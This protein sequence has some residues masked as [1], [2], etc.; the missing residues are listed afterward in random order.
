MLSAVGG[1][2]AGAW[3]RRADDDDDDD[4]DEVGA[5]GGAADNSSSLPTMRFRDPTSSKIDPSVTAAAG[6]DDDD[7]D[8]EVAVRVVSWDPNAATSSCKD[9]L[10]AEML[11]CEREKIDVDEINLTRPTQAHRTQ[12]EIESKTNGA[13]FSIVEPH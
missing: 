7:D 8:D 3:W 6:A 5:G 13:R 9:M 10:N 12:D 2:V 1:A 11:R 4:D